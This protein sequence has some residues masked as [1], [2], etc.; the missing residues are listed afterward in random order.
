M[1]AG[2]HR[3]QVG[4]AAGTARKDIAD[5]VDGHGATRRFTPLHEEIASLAVEV[6]KGQAT[7]S[8]FGGGAEFGQVHQRLPQT[9]AVDVLMG[10]LQN[11]EGSVHGGLL[12]LQVLMN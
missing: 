8:A 5:A 12:R 1:A 11:V 10:R 4:I 2:H 9:V 3:W 7:H 6:G